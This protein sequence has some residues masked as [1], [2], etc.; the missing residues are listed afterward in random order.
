M[1][2]AS[3]P[4]LHS[5]YDAP[6]W[7]SVAAH[8]TRLQKC[9]ACGTMRYPPGPTCPKCLST[10]FTWAPIAGTRRVLSWTTFHRQYL[11]AYPAPHTVVAVQLAEG[12]IMIGHVPGD[13]RARLAVNAVVRMTYVAHA[14]GYQIS[15]FELAST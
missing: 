5:H 1:T 6:T 9:D 2:M 13:Q 7:E 3:S 12:P 4:R 15:S 11:P 10:D 14:D 8:A